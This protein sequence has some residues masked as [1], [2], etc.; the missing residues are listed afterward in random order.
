MR[1]SIAVKKAQKIER[2]QEVP[3]MVVYDNDYQTYNFVAA[4][5]YY[6]HPLWEESEVVWTSDEGYIWSRY[7]INKH[8][9]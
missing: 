3:M 9:H 6:R 7:Q 1:A 8:S 2:E 4:E 5:V